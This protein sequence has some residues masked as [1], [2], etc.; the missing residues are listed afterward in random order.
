MILNLYY[1]L[2]NDWLDSFRTI[3]ALIFSIRENEGKTQNSFLV[4]HWWA[5]YIRKKVKTNS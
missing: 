1:I 3:S 5:L 4:L 2:S